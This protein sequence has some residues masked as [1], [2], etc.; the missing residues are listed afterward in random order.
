MD[1]RNILTEIT[2]SFA[3]NNVSY[4]LIGGYAM[5][6]LGAGRPT[7]DI[8]VLAEKVAS[9][10]VRKILIGLGYELNFESENVAQFVSP[11]EIFGE[12]DILW[13]FRPV[14]LDMLKRSKEMQT[15]QTLK[16]PVLLP[17][18]LI[19]LKLQAMKNNAKR[20]E[21]DWS[22]IKRIYKTCKNDMDM[23]LISAHFSLFN[24]KV[25]LEDL[26]S[27]K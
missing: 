22:D 8:D 2:Q 27:E 19:G 13:A 21:S 9:T 23:H 14:A 6:L 11:M 17:E 15:F 18:D 16:I 25:E 10:K 1:F 3:A 20:W 24:M 26:F 4:A 5:G 12:I 7:V